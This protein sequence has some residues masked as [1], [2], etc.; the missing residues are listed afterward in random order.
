M[1]QFNLSLTC[2]SH[3]A[4]LLLGGT[5]LLLP[6]WAIAAPVWFVLLIAISLRIPGILAPQQLLVFL[7]C[8]FSFALG[9]VILTAVCEDD[10]INIDDEGLSF[11][12]RFLPNL[13]FKRYHSWSQLDRIYVQERSLDNGFDGKITL[14]FRGSGFAVIDSRDMS[15]DDLQLLLMSVDMWAKRCE[16]HLEIAELR[17]LTG[18][19]CELA[20]LLDDELAKRFKPLGYSPLNAE[21][22]LQGGRLRILRKLSCGGFAATYLAH[23]NGRNIVLL[24]E[25]AGDGSFLRER[26]ILDSLRHPGISRVYDHFVENGRQYLVL[27][28][29]PGSS[30]WQIV[31]E[32]GP[33]GEGEVID[34]LLKV[35]EILRYLQSLAPAVLH[36]DLTPENLILG[37]DGHVH[38]IDFGSA[39]LLGEAAETTGKH[40]YMSPEQLAGKPLPASDIFGLGA[41]A[42]FL[43]RGG[44]R[45][46][47]RESLTGTELESLFLRCTD[48]NAERRPSPVELSEQLG[49]LKELRLLPEAVP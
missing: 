5:T 14:F 19:Q 22:F 38:L 6:I 24:K 11:P 12:L 39:R 7:L 18:G 29:K 43:L 2:Q 17:R 13:G 16:N 25:L 23:L 28:Y 1:A 4:R 30:L 10:K 9:G 15:R 47:S 46:S 36:L 42:L 45:I 48:P 33:L 37:S 26:E 49:R 31:R 27:S 20:K 34:I 44:D 40:G 32:N 41:T 21:T 3:P 35:C 8:L